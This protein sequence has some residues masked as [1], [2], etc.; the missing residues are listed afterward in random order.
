MTN[1]LKKTILEKRETN[2]LL[3][4]LD[5][6]E[7][8]RVVIL[9][10]K[11]IP[12]NDTSSMVNFLTQGQKLLRLEIASLPLYDYF[13]WFISREPSLL[14]E[15]RSKRRAKMALKKFLLDS[16]LRANVVELV[17]SAASASNTPLV[18]TIPSSSSLLG[19]CHGLSNE[20]GVPAIEESDLDTA[21]VYLADFLRD[22]A[23]T[24]I[25]GIMI[26]ES[27]NTHLAYH[28][29]TIYKPIINIGK[30]YGWTVGIHT[31]HSLRVDCTR[32]DLAITQYT[33]SC[34]IVAQPVPAKFWD[35]GS[36]C[37]SNFL[38]GKI[39]QYAL[40]ESVLEAIAGLSTQS[41]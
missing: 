23:E 28:P 11:E 36:L 8:G 3:L 24:P 27:K 15:M 40:P 1:L 39:P 17:N 37:D 34:D 22:F 20:A 14:E 26:D 29:A 10:D 25:A 30:A 19:W 38:Y 13:T 18:L 33:D 6:F 32:F 35:G 9:G 12:W 5:W 31:A 16:A 4:W 2:T 7:Y 41:P 21:T